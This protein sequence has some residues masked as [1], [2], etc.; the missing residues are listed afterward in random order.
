[1]AFREKNWK[2]IVSAHTRVNPIAQ[3]FR[4]ILE[5]YDLSVDPG[6]T[7]NLALERNDLVVSMLKSLQ[8]TFDRGR[9]TPG[10]PQNNNSNFRL[11]IP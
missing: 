7:N 10:T 8:E 6:E 2:L 9:S 11:L 5:L 1:V 4:P 3:N